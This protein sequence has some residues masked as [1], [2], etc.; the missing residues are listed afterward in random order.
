MKARKTIYASP[1]LEIVPFD[2]EDIL[3]VSTWG[4]NPGDNEEG[5]GGGSG[6]GV[7]YGDLGWT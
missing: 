2:D 1:K 5:E 7:D 6:T 3:T 4:T